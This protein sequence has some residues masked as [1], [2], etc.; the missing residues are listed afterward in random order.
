MEWLNLHTSTLDSPEV[1]G[2]EPVDRAT[3]IFLLRYCAGQ[4]NGGVIANCAGWADRKWQQLVRVT[5]AEVQ[6]PSELWRFEGADLAVNFYPIEKQREVEA[7]RNAGK[8]TVAKR[9]AH[10][11]EPAMAQ[12]DSS[13]DSSAT[14]LADTE[15][16][17]KEGNRKENGKEGEGRADGTAPLALSA[18]AAPELRKPAET[19]AQWLARLKAD[20]AY[21]GLDIDR[22]FARMKSWCDT[23]RKQPSRRRFVNWLLRCERPM[24]GPK[25]QS[26]QFAGAF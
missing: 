25:Q 6:K 2:A 8:A 20:P 18:E 14:C 24:T 11:A 15:G 1:V 23:N 16:K 5:L 19:D 12:A 9:W 13:A 7:K 3:W 10:K 26:S 22:E 21:A 17:G 4:E